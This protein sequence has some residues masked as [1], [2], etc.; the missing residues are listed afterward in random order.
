MNAPWYF[1]FESVAQD[2]KDDSHGGQYNLR[3]YRPHGRFVESLD[4]RFPGFGAAKQ[5]QGNGCPES[6]SLIQ[7]RGGCLFQETEAL[8]IKENFVTG[9]TTVTGIVANPTVVWR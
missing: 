5:R 2:W 6:G 8:E 3:F 9:K 7:K 1:A 4:T